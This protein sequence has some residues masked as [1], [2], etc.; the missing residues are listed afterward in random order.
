V[1]GRSLL[2]NFGA[3]GPLMASN[4]V[5]TMHDAAVFSQPHSFGLTFRTLYRA[6]MPWLAK[7]ARRI[8]T[9][10][11]F[12]KRELTKYLGSGVASACVVGEGWQH[13]HREAADLRILQAHQLLPKRYVLAV[14]SIAPHKNLSV[15][16]AAAERAGA[17]LDLDWVI[18]GGTDGRV[19]QQ[20]GATLGSRLKRIGFIPDGQLRALYENALLFVH[21]SLY[22]GFGIPPLEAMA[23]GC[24]VIASNAAAIPEVCGDAALYFEPHDAEGLSEHVRRVRKDSDLRRDLIVRGFERA[25][26]HSWRNTA[27]HI[28]ALL[29]DLAQTEAPLLPT[30]V[31]PRQRAPGEALTGLG[32]PHGDRRT[33]FSPFSVREASDRTPLP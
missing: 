27:E 12:S 29:D 30:P 6:C 21:P 24:P 14:G 4:Q 16:A 10:S 15:I 13:V 28:L 23:L 33:A 18:A 3:T 11:Q 20:A 5:V 26:L 7:R 9:V 25:A 19:F 31:G 17:E 32:M 8:V 2:F 1:C 22:E